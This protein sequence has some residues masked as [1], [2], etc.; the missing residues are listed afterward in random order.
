[1]RRHA[2][3]AALLLVLAISIAVNVLMFQRIGQQ[4][5]ELGQTVGR[6]L[7]ARR[8]AAPVVIVIQ[9]AP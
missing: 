9:P 8:A 7:A 1:M 2:I 3:N 6:L 4:A 5:Y